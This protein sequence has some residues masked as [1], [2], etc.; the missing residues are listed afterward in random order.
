MGC[1]GMIFGRRVMR[2][3]L[4]KNCELV[5]YRGPAANKAWLMG[6]KLWESCGGAGMMGLAVHSIPLKDCQNL[7]I[8]CI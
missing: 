7:P 6:E 5:N 4:S 1:A 3:C 2:A 8:K